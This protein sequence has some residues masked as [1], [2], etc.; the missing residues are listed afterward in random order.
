MN[1]LKTLKA[2]WYLMIGLR[3]R[4]AQV[5]HS[6]IDVLKCATKFLVAQFPL[7]GQ[8][9]NEH[10][11]AAFMISEDLEIAAPE[12]DINMYSLKYLKVINL[13]LFC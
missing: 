9:D 11:Y 2:N 8:L 1:D 10:N 6:V 4:I 7:K 12:D 13:I 5:M 3:E